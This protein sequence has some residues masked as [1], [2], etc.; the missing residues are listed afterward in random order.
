ME[1]EHLL[2]PFF[3]LLDFLPHLSLHRPVNYYH[4]K[5]VPIFLSSFESFPIVSGLLVHL[6]VVH[7]LLSLLAPSLSLNVPPF[8]LFQFL[9]KYL[10]EL[11]IFT[12]FSYF[13]LNL[14]FKCLASRLRVS[15]FPGISCSAQTPVDV[16]LREGHSY[17]EGHSH[18]RLHLHE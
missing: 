17:S 5:Y 12:Q 7:E 14:L 9:V 2:F 10:F 8:D 3:H 16:I 15:I 13:V 1:E 4:T 11:L 18:I 6:D